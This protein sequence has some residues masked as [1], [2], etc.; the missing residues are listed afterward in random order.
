MANEQIEQ[1]S[2]A[3]QAYTVFAA[4]G[5][6]VTL[7]ALALDPRSLSG[8]PVWLKPLKFFLS[9]LIFVPT[10]EFGLARTR[11]ATKHVNLI[12]RVV[13][14]G[15]LFEMIVICAQAFRGVKSHF[16]HTTPLDGALFA[17]MG[18]VISIV[19]L[20]VGWGAILILRSPF[21]GSS[22]L[23]Q[24]FGWGLLVFVVA[25]F[26]GTQMPRPT[27]AQRRLLESGQ[28]SPTIGSHFVGSEEGSTELAP[29]TAWSLESGDLRV[30]HFVGMH[31]PQ[32]LLA[33]VWVLRRR[34]WNL[35]SPQ[36]IGF[37]RAGAGL[38]FLVMGIT[39]AQAKLAESV[40]N[41]GTNSALLLVLTGT[42][43]LAIFVRAA[44][45]P[46]GFQK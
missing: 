43:T 2:K 29:L 36:V 38:G 46:K 44:I 10:L 25:A 11:A 18:I 3:L 39:F 31:V 4:V 37:V 1:N 19:V 16:N 20:F 21:A 28:S 13:A 34:K 8:E 17:A 6:I 30:S 14:S 42:E 9:T 33:L 41:L 5:T 26:L 7:L 12:R 45:G 32:L 22:A 24:A 23:K 35:N 15:L 40:F 27:P